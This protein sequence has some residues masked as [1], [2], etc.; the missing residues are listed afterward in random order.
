[1]KT[2]RR[3][4]LL[5][6]A[7]SLAT[8]LPVMA[9]TRI[10]PCN[11]MGERVGEVTHHSALVHTR[12]TKFAARNDKGFAFEPMKN[13]AAAQYAPADKRV[14]ELEGA[15]P[16][17]AG[18]VRLLYATNAELRRAKA[19]DWVQVADETDFTHQFA[20]NDLRP[21]TKY[22]YAIEATGIPHSLT[23]RG[24]VGSFTTAPKPTEFQPLTFCVATCQQYQ[25]RDDAGGFQNYRSI[26]KLYGDGGRQ[27]LLRQR[28]AHRQLG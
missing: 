3:D 28:I 15:C 23:H 1:M 18:R 2:T 16:G 22:F 24:E 10:G 20:L 14:E 26:L 12:L 11:A 7:T 5:T 4:F 19:T 25:R 8:G 9:E 27:C 17:A 21:R 6:T 13:S